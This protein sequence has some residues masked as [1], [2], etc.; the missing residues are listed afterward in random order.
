MR[1]RMLGRK[2]IYLISEEGAATDDLMKSIFLAIETKST[3]NS[4]RHFLKQVEG[5]E[6]QEAL[7]TLRA[8]TPRSRQKSVI[9]GQ[10]RLVKK[11]T[12]LVFNSSDASL[13]VIM[14]ASVSQTRLITQGLSPPHSIRPFV[15]EAETIPIS[16]KDLV[17]APTFDQPKVVDTLGDDASKDIAATSPKAKSSL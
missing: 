2:E 9:S 11:F 17:I 8:F 7:K 3:P 5:G 10:G 15:I 6:G 4:F 16:D 12:N 14:D 1:I 13:S